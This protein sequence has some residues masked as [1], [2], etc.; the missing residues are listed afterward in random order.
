MS[1]VTETAEQRFRLAFERLKSNTPEIL[2]R[3]TLVSQNNVAKEAGTDP[4]ALRKKRFPALIREIQAF[5]EIQN[6]ERERK[7]QN[8]AEKRRARDDV[9][10]IVKDL[11]NQRDDA[12]SRL[13]SARRR[14]LELLEDNRRLQARID[15]L[16]PPPIPLRK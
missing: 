7:R 10:A 2:P 15:E 6:Q 11:T 16:L 1:S 5:V 4:T 13:I 14:V 12:Q 9:K 3:G 8:R